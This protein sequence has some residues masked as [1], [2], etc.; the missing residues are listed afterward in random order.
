MSK[1]LLWKRYAVFITGL[2][3]SAIGVA[4]VTK[5]DLGTSPIT[6]IPYTLSL[7]YPLTLGMFTLIFSLV[8]IALQL[9]ILGRRFP[10]VWFLQIPV[11]FLFSAFIDASMWLL[12][13]LHPGHYILQILCLL[14]GCF[15]LGIGI[16]LEMSADVIM[17]PGESFVN[18]LHIRF[19]WDFGKVKV[20]FDCAMTGIAL[21]SGWILFGGFG[22]VREGTVIAALLVGMIARTVKLRFPDLEDRLF[23]GTENTLRVVDMEANGPVVTITRAFGSDGRIIAEALAEKLSLHLHDRDI[24]ETAARNLHLPEAEI[25]A[26]EQKM[27]SRVLYDLVAQFY[28]FS[29][30]EP[31]KDRLF[32]EE[33]KIIR[34]FA[35]E[36]NCVILGRCANVVCE[37]IPGVLRIFLYADSSYRVRRIMERNHINQ[38]EAERLTTEVERERDR[39]HKYY[40]GHERDA[41]RDYDLCINVARYPTEKIIEMIQTALRADRAESVLS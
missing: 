11:S 18:A 26:H 22:G 16:Y 30:T 41:A 14:I 36:G 19:G 39:Y 40:T 38:S 35:R 17:L 27:A 24:V 3:V 15:I 2:A 1:T 25:I 6:S 34:E 8:L 7:R 4:F 21:I 23:G 12:N 13:T 9:G 29:D 10:P 32:A 20:C 37:D 31:E 5:A 28:E 33:K